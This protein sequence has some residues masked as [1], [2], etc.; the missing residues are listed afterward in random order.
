MSTSDH[1]ITPPD[2]RGSFLTRV[3]ERDEEDQ[4]LMRQL[5]A[6][7]DDLYRREKRLE[8]LYK[9]GLGCMLLAFLI[10]GTIAVTD[11]VDVS[12]Q[13][14]V[15]RVFSLRICCMVIAG[16]HIIAFALFVM[17]ERDLPKWKREKK[18]L[19]QFLNNDRPYPD[20]L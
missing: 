4:K 17:R 8:R 13:Q 3:K 15:R 18:R 19:W 5:Q 16:L 1:S 10:A 6:E 9:T 14:A 7:A 2:S 20:D 12:H 11:F